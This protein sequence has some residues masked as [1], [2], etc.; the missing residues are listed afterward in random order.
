[1]GSEGSASYDSSSFPAI[2][3]SSFSAFLSANHLPC[4]ALCLASCLSWSR[5]LLCSFMCE[6]NHVTDQQTLTT[7]TIPE[8]FRPHTN[9]TSNAK[10]TWIMSSTKR[11]K[12]SKFFSKY[13]FTDKSNRSNSLSIVLFPRQ[14]EKEDVTKSHWNVFVTFVCLH[15]IQG[16]GCKITSS[17]LTSAPRY[18]NPLRE[19]QR[20][21]SCEYE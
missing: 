14:E 1:M 15:E 3:L 4:C 5:I 18:R 12:Y 20:D 13:G 19:H 16:K 10:K 21:A 11:H 9:V 6:R 8:I 7:T 2:F 17:A